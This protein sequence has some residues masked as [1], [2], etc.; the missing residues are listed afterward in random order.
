MFVHCSVHCFSQAKCG[1]VILVFSL[2]ALNMF[3]NNYENIKTN[4]DAKPQSAV[5]SRFF[6]LVTKETCFCCF[7]I[8]PHRA[9]SLG[10][11]FTHAMFVQTQITFLYIHAQNVS[12][13][14]LFLPT[15]DILSCLLSCLY[16]FD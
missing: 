1:E 4:N 9:L 7:F 12:Y 2:H 13:S 15:C 3:E 6:A 11:G 10:L 16:V 14:F 5:S 8:Q